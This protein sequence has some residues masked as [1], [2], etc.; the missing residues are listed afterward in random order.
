MGEDAT[1]N[2]FHSVADDPPTDT[3]VAP[4]IQPATLT[5]AYSPRGVECEAC[6]TV[7][8]RRWAAEDG[9]VCPSCV[10]W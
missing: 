6:G 1:L 7:T 10:E 5:Y 4:A 3:T 8:Q 2:D 9:L